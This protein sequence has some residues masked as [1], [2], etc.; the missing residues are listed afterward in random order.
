MSKKKIKAV[1]DL[2]LKNQEFLTPEDAQIATVTKSERQKS[3]ADD[4]NHAN[5]ATEAVELNDLQKEL[6]RFLIP[7]LRSASYRWKFRSEAIKNARVAR[8]FYKCAICKTETLKN[9]QY[10]LDHIN[11]VV[12]LT[13]WDGL[14]W[15]QYITRMFV[16]A[17]EFQVIC[18]PCHDTKSD[19]EVQMRKINREKKKNKLTK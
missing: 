6:K 7:K 14:D 9:G 8:G 4:S 3:Q 17:E 19:F 5:V 2:E 10:V 1:E 11:P 12:P 16:S 15:T 13:G 18:H